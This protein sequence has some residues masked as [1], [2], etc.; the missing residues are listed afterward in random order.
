M[1]RPQ[2]VYVLDHESNANP[3]SLTVVLLP[4]SRPAVAS[5]TRPKDRGDCQPKRDGQ[6]VQLVDWI[7]QPTGQHSRQLD[8]EEWPKDFLS[9]VALVKSF[10]FFARWAHS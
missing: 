2:G 3:H 6:L 1:S 5:A 4:S 7:G 9:L 10:Y 8:E